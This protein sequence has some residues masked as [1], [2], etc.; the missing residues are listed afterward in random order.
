MAEWESFIKDY[1]SLI[2]EMKKAMEDLKRAVM[3]SGVDD[4]GT[5]TAY[6]IDG[7]AKAIQIAVCSLVASR[8]RGDGD[9]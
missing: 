6:E 2:P 4:E 5:I 7:T 3:I 1:K 9:G 8:I